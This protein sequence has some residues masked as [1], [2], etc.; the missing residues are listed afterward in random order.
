M[1]SESK[2]EAALKIFA[3]M[4]RIDC[5]FQ[6]I[7]QSSREGYRGIKQK[8][9]KARPNHEYKLNGIGEVGVG[10]GQRRCSK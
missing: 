6:P 4:F 2:L 8:I 10:K 3:T 1:H 7:K 9:G 5:E